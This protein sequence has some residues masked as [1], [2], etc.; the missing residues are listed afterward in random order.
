MGTNKSADTVR[1]GR[2]RIAGGVVVGA[3]A[4][5]AIAIGALSSA[6]T[7]SASCYSAN[8]VT[9]YGTTGAGGCTTSTGGNYATGI[10]TNTTAAA[11]GGTG[12][13]AYASGT[14][15]TAIVTN[16]TNSSATAYNGGTATVDKAISSYA[17]ANGTGATATTTGTTTGTTTSPVRNAGS[18][19]VGTARRP[20]TA[21]AIPLRS[22]TVRDS[23]SGL[24]IVIAPARGCGR[25]PTS[26]RP[27]QSY[28][29]R[30]SPPQLLCWSARC[31]CCQTQVVDHSHGPAQ[32]G[33]TAPLVVNH[34]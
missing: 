21:K 1:R 16:S 31:G 10:G 23:Q 5:G 2:G 14:N 30:S 20:T 32:H 8:G 11:T 9:Y 18:V 3:L 27:G 29:P 13:T 25:L 34:S 19:A 26:P 12:N 28:R 33:L 24:M 17:T 22:T 6:A 7:A 4:S 15:S